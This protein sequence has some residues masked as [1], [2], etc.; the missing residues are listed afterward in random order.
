MGSATNNCKILF[1]SFKFGLYVD[2]TVSL[3]SLENEMKV[4]ERIFLTPGDNYVLW[5]DDCPL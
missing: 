1:L 5:G 3:G 4:Y 2:G